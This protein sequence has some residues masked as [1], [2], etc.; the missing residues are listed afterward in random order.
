MMIN[1]C[2]VEP[3]TRVSSVLGPDAVQMLGPPASAQY[4][5][6]SRIGL[7]CDTVRPSPSGANSLL[8]HNNLDL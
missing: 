4:M 8:K 5:L 1:P 2:S 6:L 3:L 7:N